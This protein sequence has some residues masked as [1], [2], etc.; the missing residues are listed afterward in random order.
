MQIVNVFWRELT[1]RFN[2]LSCVKRLIASLNLEFSHHLKSIVL[3]VSVS[4]GGAVSASDWN[5][6]M[7]PIQTMYIYPT[8][9]VIVQGNAYAG[10]ASCV[11]DNAW[12]FMW[13]DFDAATASRIHSML[14]SAHISKT[15]IKPIFAANQ[16]GP[17]GK[18]KFTGHLVM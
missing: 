1:V 10:T 13:S 7:A 8:Y 2:S 9:A 17:E 11:N 16:C 18:K 15:P 12:S 6:A 3:V 4:L 14:V 5:G